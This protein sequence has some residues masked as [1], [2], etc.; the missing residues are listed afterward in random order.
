MAS[1]PT[2]K[3]KYRRRRGGKTDFHSRLRGLSGGE[4]MFV[5]RVLNKRVITELMQYSEK[6]DKTLVYA[7]SAEL[8]KKYGW[9]GHGGNTPSAYLTGYLCGL[10]AV[11]QKIKKAYSNVGLHSKVKGASVFAAI[12]GAVDAGLEIPH[13]KSAFPSDERIRGSHIS[14]E[15]T[16]NFDETM[17]KVKA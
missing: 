1:K 17:K 10:K 16:K 6:G 4:P 5:V 8:R 3:V 14:Q 9:N 7:D 15:L 12:K 13:E 2:Y 11:K